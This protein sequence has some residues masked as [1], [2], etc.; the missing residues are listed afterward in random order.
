MF[1]SCI[2]EELHLDVPHQWKVK[3]LRQVHRFAAVWQCHCSPQ[4]TNPQWGESVDDEHAAAAADDDDNDDDGELD[5]YKVV[6][7]EAKQYDVLGLLNQKSKKY[8]VTQSNAQQGIRYLSSTCWAPSLYLNL[9]QD[10]QHWKSWQLPNISSQTCFSRLSSTWGAQCVVSQVACLTSVAQK[11]SRWV[12]TDKKLALKVS[13]SR[14]KSG[15]WSA[16]PAPASAS[17]RRTACWA[18]LNCGTRWNHLELYWG[19]GV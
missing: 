12:T 16:P 3:L 19:I 17:S 13:E 2:C 1:F 4:K 9:L 6:N 18:K 5:E 7:N 15:V 14:Q 11:R 10:P 8:F